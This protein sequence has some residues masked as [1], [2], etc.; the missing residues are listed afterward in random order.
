[1]THVQSFAAASDVST[2]H[3]S[4]PHHYRANIQGFR[5]YVHQ[6]TDN[7]ELLS[8]LLGQIVKDKVQLYRHQRG[9]N[10]ERVTVPIKNLET[11]AKE[12]EIYDVGGFVK[13]RVFAANGYKVVG[14]SV[15]KV[16]VRVQESL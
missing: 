6:A 5:K 10:P 1:M 11:R 14:D 3:A 9:E 2:V 4:P 7:D 16:F 8:F 13:S 12:L 15:E